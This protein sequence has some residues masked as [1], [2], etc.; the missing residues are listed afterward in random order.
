MPRRKPT[1]PPTLPERNRAWQQAGLPALSDEQLTCLAETGALPAAL[2]NWWLWFR[3]T[4]RKRPEE[5]YCLISYDIEN[6]KIRRLVAKT[7]L[8]EGCVRIQK[9]VF[10]A[11]MHRKR[12]ERLTDLLRQIQQLY[13][14]TDSIMLLPVGEDMLNSLRCIG[15][16]FE[17]EQLTAPKHTLFF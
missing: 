16:S 5:M 12:Y 2:A 13:E 9:S 10:F 17:V 14:N 3:Q 8:R 11:R 1:P 7:L 15:Q 4:T 6:N